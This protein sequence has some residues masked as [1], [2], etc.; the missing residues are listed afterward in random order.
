MYTKVKPLLS[1]T[2]KKKKKLE[3]VNMVFMKGTFIIFYEKTLESLQ[4]HCIHTMSHWSSGLPVID[5]CGL[6]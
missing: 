3:I 5:H 1:N 6:V 2:V 4:S